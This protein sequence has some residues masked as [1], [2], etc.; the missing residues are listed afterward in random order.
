MA[1]EH[2]D[3][4]RRKWLLYR[5][6]GEHSA[7]CQR[8]PFAALPKRVFLDTN[9]LNL[10]VRYGEAIFELQQIPTDVD[11]TRSNDVEALIH[12]FQTGQRMGWPILASRKSLEEL[13]R[14]PEEHGRARLVA[15]RPA[16]IAATALVPAPTKGSSTT[17]PAFENERTHRSASSCGNWHG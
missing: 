7:D 15:S 10:I 16:L 11:E 14:T 1:L 9:V 17:S 13:E 5:T 6:P 4:H 12:I 8:Y 3:P 2:W